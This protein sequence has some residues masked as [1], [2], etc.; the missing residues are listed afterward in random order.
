MLHNYLLPQQVPMAEASL[1]YVVVVA[2]VKTF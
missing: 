2:A 1:T